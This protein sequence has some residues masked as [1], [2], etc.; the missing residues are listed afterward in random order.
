MMEEQKAYEIT[1]RETTPAMLLNLAIDKGADIDK[2]EKLMDLQIKWEAQQ[3]RKAYAV[4]MAEFKKS[5]PEIEKDRHVSY[6]TKDG[7]TTSYD[8]ATLANVTEKINAA[9]SQHGLTASWEVKQEERGITVTCRITHVLGH[10]ESTSITAPPDQSGGKNAIQSIGSTISYLERYSLLA[11]TGLSTYD[12]DDDGV[13]E[14]F[15]T[16]EQATT[17]LDMI[18][19]KGVDA[20]KFLVYMSADTINKIHASDYDKAIKALK[21]AKGKAA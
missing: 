13:A 20:G 7:G 19:K 2:L 11:L 8:H 4:A 17:I 1:T 12:Q 6:K 16:D 21:I 14:E 18:D 3:A 15:I 9:L 10:S 5:P